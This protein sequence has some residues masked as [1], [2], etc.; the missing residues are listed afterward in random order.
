MAQRRT[1]TRAPVSPLG[2]HDRDFDGLLRFIKEREIIPAEHECNRQGL[3]A[4]TDARPTLLRRFL[5]LADATSVAWR[6]MRQEYVDGAIF[7][8]ERY[9]VPIISHGFTR[10][11]A[12]GALLWWGFLGTWYGNYERAIRDVADAVGVPV[13][14]SNGWHRSILGIGRDLASRVLRTNRRLFNGHLRVC[15]NFRNTIHNGGVHDPAGKRQRVTYKR[16]RFD[17]VP[18]QVPQVPT[19]YHWVLWFGDAVRHWDAL[20]RSPKVAAIRQIVPTNP[21]E[22]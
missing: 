14:K 12:Y 21:V 22:W 13:T 16:Q 11:S 19:E 4:L 18:G 8:S 20:V 5:V 9:P 1:P 15:Q 6:A 10:E 2:N 17:F 3:D 7:P